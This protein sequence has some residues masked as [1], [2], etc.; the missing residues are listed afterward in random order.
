MERA[1]LK[2]STPKTTQDPKSPPEVI[3]ITSDDEIS[4]VAEASP[5]PKKR[6]GPLRAM[7]RAERSQLEVEPDGEVQVLTQKIDSNHFHATKRVKS[8]SETQNEAAGNAV[9]IS[10]DNPSSLCP[11]STPGDP[12]VT[13]VPKVDTS[14]TVRCG[15]CGQHF[16][17]FLQI[18]D[19]IRTCQPEI[20]SLQKLLESGA[21]SSQQVV[22]DLTSDDVEE[23]QQ[24]E[25][26]FDEEIETDFDSLD[27]WLDFRLRLCF[28][29]VTKTAASPASPTTC[30]ICGREFQDDRSILSHVVNDHLLDYQPDR[31]ALVPSVEIAEIERDLED[32]FHRLVKLLAADDNGQPIT[33]EKPVK[34]GTCG[35][36]FLDEESLKDH[37]PLAHQ[38]EE[39]SQAPVFRSGHLVEL[40]FLFFCQISS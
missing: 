1:H 33:R 9:Q 7:K 6:I 2:S 32:R 17:D 20:K 30:G 15:Q 4:V 34:C 18:S 39:K 40:L 11:S 35:G 21:E 37:I 22:H 13:D 5:K 16:V 19:H 28:V 26:E 24:D 14:L 12:S 31:V 10:F 8:I 23:V 27:S 3:E 25:A 38:V 29:S 36:S